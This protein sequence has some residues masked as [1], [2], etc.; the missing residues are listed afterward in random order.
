MEFTTS[1]WLLVILALI[2][3]FLAGYFKFKPQVPPVRHKGRKFTTGEEVRVPAKKGGT[4]SFEDELG[5][6]FQ[7]RLPEQIPPREITFTRVKLIPL[8]ELP[9]PDNKPVHRIIIHLKAKDANGEVGRFHPM[10]TTISKYTEEDLGYVDGD[11][12]R[13]RRFYNDG[14]EWIELGMPKDAVD[15][16]NRTVTAYVTSFSSCGTI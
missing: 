10:M 9:N 7:V 11:P 8:A 12:K 14:I 1:A 6:E 13:L 2:L 15:T 4:V 5:E 3:G 16:K